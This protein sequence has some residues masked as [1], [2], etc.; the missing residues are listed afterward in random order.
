MCWQQFSAEASQIVVK[1]G[2]EQQLVTEQGRAGMI[3]AETD[4]DFAYLGAPHLPLPL[5]SGNFGSWSWSWQP[6]IASNNQ[7]VNRNPPKH[8]VLH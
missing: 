1:F 5:R 6:V 4:S 7:H 3:F 2:K 8:A